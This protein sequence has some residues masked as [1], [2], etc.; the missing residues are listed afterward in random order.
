MP[1][2]DSPWLTTQST[3][4]DHRLADTVTCGERDE[5]PGGDL[6]DCFRNDADNKVE[7]LEDVTTLGD[8]Y[9]ARLILPGSAGSPSRPTCAGPGRSCRG[10]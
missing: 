8:V 6:S 1:R 7:D 5:L 3:V 10:T 2:R 9:D 4:G